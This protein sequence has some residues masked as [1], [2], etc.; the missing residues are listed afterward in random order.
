MRGLTLALVAVGLVVCATA[1]ARHETGRFDRVNSRGTSGRSTRGMPVPS[2]GT[3]SLF[4]FAP[5]SGTGMGTACACAA[6]TGRDGETMTYSRTGTAACTATAAGG[7]STTGIA[8]GDLALCAANQPRVEYD[9]AGTLGLLVEEARTNYA[10]RSEE[11]ND[12]S[13]Q[14]YNA[15]ASAPTKNATDAAVSPWGTTAAED[16]TFGAT[17][18][19]QD[20]YLWKTPTG[21]TAAACAE[22]VYVKGYSGSG[23]MDI[24]SSNASCTSCAY[25]STSWTRCVHLA[26]LGTYIIIGNSGVGNGGVARSSNRVY[27]VGAQ[28]ELGAFA[29]SYIPTTSASAARGADVASVALA[30]GLAFGS[31]GATVNVLGFGTTR[32][33]ATPWVASTDYWQPRITTAGAT[34][35]YTYVSSTADTVSLGTTTAGTS[36]RVTQYRTSTPTLCGT[37]G[38]GAATCDGTGVGATITTSGGTGK[39]Y[40]GTHSSTGSELN[41]VVS[42]V[43]LD[44]SPTVCQ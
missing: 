39:V 26:A 27:L 16:V 28:A 8:N 21:C 42:R 10:L 1:Y 29:T 6:V 30:N 40:L 43:C 25:V 33:A 14:V 7:L 9:G 15:G 2:T 17:V 22:S 3:A 11:F 31:F 35:A 36:T 23:T 44:S 19:A 37:V 4:E 41:G 12:A 38:G 5:S 13:W 32:P 18:G 24:C 34:S 20:S